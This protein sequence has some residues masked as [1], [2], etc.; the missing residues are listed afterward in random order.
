M[1]QRPSQLVQWL[2]HNFI[3]FFKLNIKIFAYHDVLG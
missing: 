1:N 2:I 3:L